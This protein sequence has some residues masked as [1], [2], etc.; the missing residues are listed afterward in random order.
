[1][2]PLEWKFRELIAALGG[3]GAVSQLFVAYGFEAPPVETIKGWRLRNS[4]PG[5]YLPALLII[6]QERGI[7]PKLSALYKGASK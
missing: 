2:H 4:I 5:R 7:L 1:M 6:A 3:P